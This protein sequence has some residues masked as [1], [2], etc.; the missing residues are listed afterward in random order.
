ML[1]RHVVYL[2][3]L[4]VGLVACQDCPPLPPF[5]LGP[6]V[7]QR[8]EDIPQGCSDYE[9]LVGKDAPFIH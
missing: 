9:I 4:G 3:Y 6:P 8:P 5:E 2:Y 1:Y 7:P